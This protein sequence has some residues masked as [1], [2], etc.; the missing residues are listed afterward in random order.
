MKW[1]GVMPAITTPFRD[2]LSLDAGLLV[3][4]IGALV[5]AGCTGVVA[6]GSLGEGG[7]LSK[8]E[9]KAVL[10][11]CREAL[12]GRAAL[13]AGI[14]A[15]FYAR[16]RH[17]RAAAAVGQDERAAQGIGVDP[18]RARVVAVTLGAL[19][20]GVAGS[21]SVSYPGFDI[22]AYRL[23]ADIAAVAALVLGGAGSAF[24]P[25]FGAALVAI[26][27]VAPAT[28]EHA[29]AL[30]AVALLAATIVLP[31][32]VASIFSRAARR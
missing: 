6:L 5:E 3:K 24:G 27:A 1:Q 17:G 4:Q 26:G 8:D 25:L 12:A 21:L 9:K 29:T 31:G 15:W 13:V 30:N 2:D 20:A 28:K 18:V 19:L 32:G 14:A 11:L 7:S 10:R 22:T 23:H 16:S